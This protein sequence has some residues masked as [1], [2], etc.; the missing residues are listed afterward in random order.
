M[1]TT[2]HYQTVRSDAHDVFKYIDDVAN[3][4]ELFPPCK[5][6]DI[7]EYTNTRQLIRITAD[8]HGCTMS[9]ETERIVD[10]QSLRV[11]FRQTKPQYPVTAMSGEWLCEQQFPCQA[12]IT[13]THAVEVAT[14]CNERRNLEHVLKAIDSNSKQELAA[15]K[16]AAEQVTVH[17]FEDRIW[18]RAD[19]ADIFQILFRAEQWPTFLPHCPKLQ[20]V[21]DD[22]QNQELLMTV[23]TPRG[24]E[25]IRTVRL[26][27]PPFLL[28]YF[29][30]LPPAPLRTH[31]G[32]WHIKP[33]GEG[34]EIIATHT[35]TVQPSIGE[36]ETSI[37]LRVQEAI[38]NNSLATLR[39]IADSVRK[40]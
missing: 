12:L 27:E 16:Q 33:V 34:V 10:R 18:I 22:G 24:E 35:V 8:A 20:V 7:L 36:A 9:W 2:V 28:K 32:A 37:L 11:S 19:A 17:C 5:N 40:G 15:I 21:Y 26:A 29:Q 13:L 25:L 6:V 38:R 3:W 39:S 30:T 14:G 31:H 23:S 1:V 4:P